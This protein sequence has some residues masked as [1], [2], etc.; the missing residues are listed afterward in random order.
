MMTVRFE[1]RV[2]FATVAMCIATVTTTAAWAEGEY[3]IDYRVRVQ[4]T[5]KAARVTVEVDNAS[6]AVRQVK[7]RVDLD[8]H[9]EFAGDGDISV[10]GDV[11]SWQPPT[12][13][14]TFT[15]TFRIDHLRDE[16]SYDARCAASWA[17][18]RGD[19]LVPPATVRTLKGAESS[20][21]LHLN[22]PEGWSAAAPYKRSADGS[23]VIDHANRR[24]DRPIGWLIV[25]K[26]GVTRE[27]IA[28][29]Y[30]AVAGP[31]GQHLHRMDVTALLRW[32][33]PSL[34]DML[35]PLPERMLIV[36]A[37]D[38][39]WRGGLSAPR[40]MFLHGDR[41]LISEDGTSPVLHELV[42]SAL[43]LEPGPGGDWVIEGLAEYYSMEVLAQS[44]TISRKRHG[45][46]MKKMADRGSSVKQLETDDASG[47][48]TARAV[49]VLRALDAEV[50]TATDGRAR[51][52]DAVR[53]LTASGGKVT[54]ESLRV[55]AEEV[56]GT[57][58]TDFFT[59]QGVGSDG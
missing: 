1:W 2:L 22:V 7:W 19:D 48:L 37:R 56:S 40:S 47:A 5:E 44:G 6:G 46:V 33:L 39:M 54:S 45:K 16:L 53:L 51:L 42:H 10:D 59:S 29:S 55:A 9:R 18:F 11:V 15:Y 28:G 8:R 35:G 25:G 36:M 30:T 21:H 26:L 23:F 43:R 57:D 31:R 58:L 12:G 52:A 14:A 3:R 41:P 49:T 50:K 24:F 38:P 32:T 4:P 34:R 27:R 20:A 17:I 13:P